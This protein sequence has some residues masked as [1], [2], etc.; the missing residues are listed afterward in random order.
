MNRCWTFS[1]PSWKVL[2]MF[3]ICIHFIVNTGF[4]VCICSTWNQ[5]DRDANTAQLHKTPPTTVANFRE[6]NK[7]PQ[8]Q[9]KPNIFWWFIIINI[10]YYQ[11]FI[12]NKWACN[13]L[14]WNHSFIY[15]T[16]M[17]KLQQKWEQNSSSHVSRIGLE[18]W[19]KEKST[20]A[21]KGSCNIATYL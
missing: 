12:T 13:I 14:H 4:S 8:L 18:R 2:R 21:S 1:E 5:R 9:N 10:I 15:F 19:K 17:S 3:N 16:K 6:T 11:L 7:Q 20:R